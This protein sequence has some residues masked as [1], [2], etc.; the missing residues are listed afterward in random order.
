MHVS[1]SAHT[2]P[3]HPASWQEKNRFNKEGVLVVQSQ[4]HRTQL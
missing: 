2:T 1:M 4:R 3:Q